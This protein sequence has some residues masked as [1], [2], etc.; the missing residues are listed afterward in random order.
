MREQST[1]RDHALV[2]IGVTVI[3]RNLTL[4]GEKQATNHACCQQCLA[5]IQ[6]GQRRILTCE[7]YMWKILA[8]EQ[9]AHI[10]TLVFLIG[11]I[12]EVHREELD[13]I[14]LGEDTNLSTITEGCRQQFHV[15]VV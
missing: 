5:G 10:R 1:C 4:V 6:S 12:L 11:S 13:G 14:L 8:S 7:P 15:V 2:G 3:Q 9:L